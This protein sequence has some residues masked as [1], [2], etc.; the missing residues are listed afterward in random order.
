MQSLCTTL[1]EQS[2]LSDKKIFF[3]SVIESIIIKK[4][5]NLDEISELINPNNN[6][7]SNYRI[8]QRFFKYFNVCFTNLAKILMNSLSKD[9]KILI[10]DRTQWK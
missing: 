8:L 2:Q 9:K 6:K 3:F 4:T 10:K 5:I 1:K 7:M